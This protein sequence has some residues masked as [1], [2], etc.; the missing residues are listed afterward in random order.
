MQ[1]QERHR[2]RGWRGLLKGAGLVLLAVAVLGNSA[3]AQEDKPAEIRIGLP[4]QSAGSKPFIGGPLGLAY[5]RHSLEQA[6]E[7]QG[8]KV[9][10]SFFKGAGPAVNEALANQQLD[11]AYLG[12]LRRLSVVPAGCL[13]KCCWGRAAPVRIWRRRRSPALRG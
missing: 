10:W 1:Q 6:F 4:D 8:I 3:R 11:V 13:P 2:Y 9:R 7:P 12:D 5:I